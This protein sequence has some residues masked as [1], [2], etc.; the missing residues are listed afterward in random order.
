MKEKV[1]EHIFDR[2]RS[3]Q[4]DDSDI[5][6]LKHLLSQQQPAEEEEEFEGM[7]LDWIRFQTWKSHLAGFLLS[8]SK[9]LQ[10]EKNY[11]LDIELI[12]YCKRLEQFNKKEFAWEWYKNSHGVFMSK[13]DEV[14]TKQ[15]FEQEWKEQA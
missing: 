10:P 14:L 7:K 13:L 9:H 6:Y 2:M 3:R 11:D 8:R 15:M 12:E 1:L 4:T 5:D